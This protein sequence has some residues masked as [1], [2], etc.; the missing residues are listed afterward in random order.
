VA[1]NGIFKNE[2]E[3]QRGGRRG[4]RLEGEGDVVGRR[5][6]RGRRSVEGIK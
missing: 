6:R 4:R 3:I 1:W 2:W 5:R